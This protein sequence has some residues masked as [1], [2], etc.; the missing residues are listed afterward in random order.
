MYE[1]QSVSEADPKEAQQ[2][3][4]FKAPPHSGNDVR[5]ALEAA[6]QKTLEI[7]EG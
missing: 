1:V 4:C 6:G 3:Q 7:S 5:A 2:Y